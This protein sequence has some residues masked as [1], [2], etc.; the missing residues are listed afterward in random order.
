MIKDAVAVFA[1]A[2]IYNDTRALTESEVNPID[3]YSFD[4]EQEPNSIGRD[5]LDNLNE[6]IEMRCSPTKWFCD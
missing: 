5:I 2:L 3:C 1:K 4:P 6:V